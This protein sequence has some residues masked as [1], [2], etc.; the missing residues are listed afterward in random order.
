MTT[1]LFSLALIV[2]IIALIAMLMIAKH[3]TKLIDEI[4]EKL[5]QHH[6]LCDWQD[7]EQYLAKIEDELDPIM[8]Y[9]NEL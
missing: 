1:L 7:H 6:K 2:L 3:L 4:K 9:D 8:W 5:E